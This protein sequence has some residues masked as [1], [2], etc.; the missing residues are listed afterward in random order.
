MNNHIYQLGHLSKRDVAIVGLFLFAILVPYIMSTK[1]MTV[2]PTDIIQLG[3]LLFSFFAG[4]VFILEDILPS[5]Y[6][7]IFHRLN[8]GLRHLDN[9]GPPTLE[10]ETEM[11]ILTWENEGFRETYKMLKHFFPNIPLPLKREDTE[12]EA[13]R[14]VSICIEKSLSFGAQQALEGVT[15][16]P[17]FIWDTSKRRHQLISKDALSWYAAT[18]RQRTLNRIGFFLLVLSMLIQ[19]SQ[20]FIRFG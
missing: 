12:I 15:P 2:V 11:A 14:T 20:L 13:G 18:Y 10:R 1:T 3:G 5:I 6:A 17:V 9:F 16:N 8:V 4:I 7:L 19:S